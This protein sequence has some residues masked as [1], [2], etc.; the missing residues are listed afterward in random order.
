MLPHSARLARM[1]SDG[2]PLQIQPVLDWSPDWATWYPLDVLSGSHTQDR[3][4]TVRWTLSGTVAKTVPPGFDGIHPYGCRLRL[5]LAVSYLGSSPEYIPAG[6]YS[7]TG[8][9]SNFNNLSITG[10]SF[11]QDVIDATFPVPRN[12]P[13]NRTMTYR[14][15]AEKLIT[16]AVPDARFVWDP[17]LSVYAPMIAMAVDS[18]R[19]S[20]IHGQ[21]NDASVATALGADALC[22]ASGAF[23]F[24]RRPS[25][26]DAPVWTVSEGTQTKIASATAYDRQNVFNLVVVTGTPADGSNPIGP[27][28]VWDD[29]PASPTYAGPDPV[30]HPELAGHFG[31][32]SYRYDSPLLTSERQAWQVGKAIL[33]DLVGESKTVSFSGRYNPCQ[34]AGDVVLITRDDGQLENHLVDSLSYTWG[35]GIAAYTTRSTKQEVTVSV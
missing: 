26:A 35:T 3:T 18:D 25:L 10:S 7:V 12:L 32:K 22:D 29:D 11:E 24:V 2:T 1:L 16:E 21:A 15:Q 9:T 28:F 19:W 6:M 34:E 20:V 13:D 8:V 4:S 23:S 30:K 17:R 27:V 31:V 5:Q 14:R 33:A